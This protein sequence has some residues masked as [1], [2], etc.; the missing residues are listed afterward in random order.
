MNT[1]QNKNGMENEIHLN[2]FIRNLFPIRISPSPIRVIRVHPRLNSLPVLNPSHPCSSVANSF[3]LLLLPPRKL[4]RPP[5]NRVA[6]RLAY[7]AALQ[8][9]L[10][11]TLDAHR[12]HAASESFIRARTRH[13]RLRAV[14]KTR[15]GLSNAEKESSTAGIEPFRVERGEQTLERE[16]SALERE[17]QILERERSEVD[18]EEQPAPKAL[19]KLERGRP[20]LERERLLAGAEE[21]SG[22]PNGGRTGVIT[23]ALGDRKWA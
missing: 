3:R 10:Q 17:E 11:R 1:D 5:R 2:P 12:R 21:H 9:M 23:G 19:F 18:R 4:R 22:E 14:S 20:A 16:P 15:L 7:R 6:H 13:T 8:P